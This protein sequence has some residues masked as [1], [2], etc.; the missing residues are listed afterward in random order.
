[1]ERGP[2]LNPALLFVVIEKKEK[3][4]HFRIFYPKNVGLSFSQ[5]EQ[6]TSGYLY[7]LSVVFV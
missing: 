5:Q 6:N 1:M 7:Y 4:P 2:S 3:N